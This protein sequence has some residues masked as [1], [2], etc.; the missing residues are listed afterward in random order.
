MKQKILLAL[1][2]IPFL[3]MLSAGLILKELSSP[4][5][6][7]QEQIIDVN[8]GESVYRVADNLHNMEVLSWPR[9][10]VWYARLFD[11]TAIKAGEYRIDPQMSPLQIL[12]DMN[13]ARVIEYQVTLVEGWTSADAIRALQ[14][15]PGIVS[16]IAV[17][18]HES[19]LSAVGADQRFEHSE[20]LFFPDTYR[21]T[22]G[23]RDRDILRRAYQRMMRE[24]EDAWRQVDG[25]NLPYSNDYEVLIMASI[26]ER[27]TAVDAERDKI[28]GVF[29]NR[30]QKGM[31]L[32]TDPT[33][34]Y[35]MGDSF[36]GRIT[37]RDL[38]TPTPYNTYTHHGLPPTPIALPGRASLQAAVNP[39]PTDKLYFVGRGDGH[40]HFSATLEEHNKAVRRYQLSRP[41]D[42]R[43]TPLPQTQNNE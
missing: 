27:E 14:N 9:L 15:T 8:F 16:T 22:R 21:Y 18:S 40:H 43:S 26:I 2:L 7:P 37:R 35:G 41:D 20:G 5:D 38:R 6:L 24:L 3:L 39:R 25:R 30:L 33:V 29:V 12:D 23:S 17:D 11:M 1:C 36:Q 10:W 31:R 4:L 32:Q 13:K 19:I 42:Y 34:I 28:A